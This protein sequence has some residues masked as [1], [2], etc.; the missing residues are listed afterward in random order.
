MGCPTS[1]FPKKANPRQRDSSCQRADRQREGPTVPC[2]ETWLLDTCHPENSNRET[3]KST[4]EEVALEAQGSKKTPIL[5]PTPSPSPQGGGGVSRGMKRAPHPA[6][7][8]SQAPR[9]RQASAGRR[10]RQGALHRIHNLTCLKGN[11]TGQEDIF[12]T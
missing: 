6:P 1:T 9:C 11:E 8:H 7:L 4:E 3:T 10:G 5:A 2:L 12:N